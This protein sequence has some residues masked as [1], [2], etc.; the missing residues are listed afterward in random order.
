MGD[1]FKYCGENVYTTIKELFISNCAKIYWSPF[2][3]YPHFVSDLLQ[4]KNLSLED[5]DE[6]VLMKTL[7]DE[8][9]LADEKHEKSLTISDPSVVYSAFFLYFLM[10]TLNL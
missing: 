7:T 6:H 4:A 8:M 2:P 1:F 9:E 5:N 3:N 10:D